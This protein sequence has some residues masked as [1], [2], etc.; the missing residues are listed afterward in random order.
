MTMNSSLRLDKAQPINGGDDASCHIESSSQAVMSS[1]GTGAEASNGNNVTSEAVNS[2]VVNKN[3]ATLM[4]S[5]DRKSFDAK[6]EILSEKEHKLSASFKNKFITKEFNTGVEG[7][8]SVIVS[9]VRDPSLF[10]VHLITDDVRMFDS[11][12]EEMNQYYN[13]NGE[14]LILSLFS[15]YYSTVTQY[16]FVLYCLDII[17]Y[18]IT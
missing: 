14:A 18:Y 9:S 15:Q 1:E 12:M 5:G 2:D 8:C 16:Y 3:E 4:A 6:A 10:Y 7:F 13:N 11:M 17:Q